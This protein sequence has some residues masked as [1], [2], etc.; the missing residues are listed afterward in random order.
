MKWQQ[1]DADTHILQT[2][3]GIV[4]ERIA[5]NESCALVFIPRGRLITNGEGKALDIVTSPDPM[6]AKVQGVLS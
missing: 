5:E 4:L 3:A 1:L 2:T 6:S